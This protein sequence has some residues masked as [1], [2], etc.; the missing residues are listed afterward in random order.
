MKFI[1]N[2]SNRNGS[3]PKRQFHFWFKQGLL[4]VEQGIALANAIG[5][6]S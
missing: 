1:L 2:K 3:V 4:Q 5:E 6:P